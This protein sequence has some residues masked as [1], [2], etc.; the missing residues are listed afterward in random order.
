MTNEQLIEYNVRAMLEC[1]EQG[2]KDSARHHSQRLAD[3]IAKRTQ[4]EIKSM[5]EQKGLV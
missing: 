1:Y 4:E 3:L 2:D 5:E